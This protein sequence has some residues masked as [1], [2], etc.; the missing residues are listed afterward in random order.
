LAASIESI[1]ASLS[2]FGRRSWSVP[3][4]ARSV[5]AQ[6]AF[7]RTPVS[8]GAMP[9]IGRDMFHAELLE[10]PADLR[11]MVPVDLARLGR[12]EI[13]RAPVRG[14]RGANAKPRRARGRSRPCLVIGCTPLLLSGSISERKAS[15]KSFAIAAGCTCMKL[16]PR[17][18]PLTLTIVMAMALGACI[19]AAPPLLRLGLALRPPSSLVACCSA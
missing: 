4:S 5:R 6:R 14:C 17:K 7:E 10:R 3:K 15:V 18:R 9:R 11:Q 2:S 1:P 12:V 8:R 16:W 13:V 19:S